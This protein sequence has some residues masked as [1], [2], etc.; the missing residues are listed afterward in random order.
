MRP[1]CMAGTRLAARPPQPRR[2]GGVSGGRGGYCHLAEAQGTSG[3]LGLQ[4]LLRSHW[5]K[6]SDGYRA[7]EVL[8]HLPGSVQPALLRRVAVSRYQLSRAG[9]PASA[10]GSCTFSSPLTFPHLPPPHLPPS[11]L[12]STPLSPHADAFRTPH[13]SHCSPSLTSLRW[14]RSYRKEPPREGGWAQK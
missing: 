1:G 11:P 2:E 7:A 4:R 14:R 6:A 12:H 3:T 10:D 13:H 8:L 5:S 9:I